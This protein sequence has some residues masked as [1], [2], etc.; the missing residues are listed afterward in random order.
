MK[1]KNAE[2]QSIYPPPP[3]SSSVKLPSSPITYPPNPSSAWLPTLS[4]TSKPKPNPKPRPDEAFVRA[5]SPSPSSG[6]WSSFVDAN[7]C[8]GKGRL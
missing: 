3:S 7:G 6:A 4:P 2:D 8:V 1:I 5:I